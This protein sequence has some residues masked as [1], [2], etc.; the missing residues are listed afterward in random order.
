MKRSKII[1]VVILRIIR[2]SKAMM[3]EEIMRKSRNDAAKL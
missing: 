3:G 2:W 1:K